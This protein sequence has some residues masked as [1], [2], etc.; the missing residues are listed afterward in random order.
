M[1]L[2]KPISSSSSPS[3]VKDFLDIGHDWNEQ[4]W[5]KKFASIFK[6]AP[7]KIGKSDFKKALFEKM[8]T[9]EGT[10][11]TV[12]AD[13]F[14]LR[15]SQHDGIAIVDASVFFMSLELKRGT[16]TGQ[17]WAEMMLDELKKLAVG[18]SVVY[19]V[20][21]TPCPDFYAKLPEQWRRSR[22]AAR[23]NPD[24]R[25]FDA[26]QRPFSLSAVYTQKDFAEIKE[27]REARYPYMH[28]VFSHALGMFA[29]TKIKAVFQLDGIFVHERQQC[30]LD[31]EGAQATILGIRI[32]FSGTGD[33]P[34]FEDAPWLREV[35]ADRKIF[36]WA[37]HILGKATEIPRIFISTFDTDVL[38]SAL[39][40]FE[41]FSDEALKKITIELFWENTSH[42]FLYADIVKFVRGSPLTARTLVAL[43]MCVTGC[44]YVTSWYSLAPETENPHDK[45]D[46]WT[47]ALKAKM[48]DLSGYTTQMLFL[49]SID[50]KTKL[51]N[52]VVLEEM[53]NK[54]CPKS[55]MVLDFGI[56][57]RQIAAA[58]AYYG[59]PLQLESAQAIN[60][61]FQSHLEFERA[62]PASSSSSSSSK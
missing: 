55:G 38:Y 27:T 56:R 62:L 20:A 21:D 58:M 34:V 25:P 53:I 32:I 16:I 8:S 57:A 40:L 37:L 45:V 47:K 22:E 35:E 54:I 30:F 29:S 5:T 3:W 42:N 4:L 23:K 48:H 51:I 46:K 61:L 19:L 44:D 33:K 14:A 6:R 1:A 50:G 59:F 41:L 26:R 60:D 2:S 11:Y 49:N 36:Q 28:A 7:F 18:F 39:L 17:E 9:M 15:G 43:W 13:K 12:R 10:T 31:D 52:P 24:H